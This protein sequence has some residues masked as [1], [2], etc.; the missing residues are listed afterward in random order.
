MVEPHFALVG[1]ITANFI[2]TDPPWPKIDYKRILHAILWWGNKET[3]NT[4]YRSADCMDNKGD[5][6]NAAPGCPFDS[7]NTISFSTMMKR[8]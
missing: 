1:P 7:I 8:E 3:Q 6:A 4:Q 2:S 5:T